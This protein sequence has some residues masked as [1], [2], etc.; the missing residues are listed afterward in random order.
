MRFSLLI[1]ISIFISQSLFSNSLDLYISDV[2][3]THVQDCYGDA[4]GIIVITAEG[5]QTPYSYSVEIGD[6][7]NYQTSNTFTGLIAGTY[8]IKVKDAFNVVVQTY[9]NVY[10]PDPIQIY[11][12]TVTN[13]DGCYGDANGSI[14]ISANGGTGTLTYSINNGSSFQASDNF[15]NLTAGFYTVVVKDGND[16]EVTG[17]DLE[18]TQPDKLELSSVSTM[19]VTGCYNY[20]NGIIDIA[21]TG[22]TEP[23][24][25]SVNNG[26]DFQSGASFTGLDAGSYDIIIKDA[27]DCSISGGNYILTQPDELVIDNIQHTNVGCNGEST[28]DITIT[29]SGGTG[30]LEY[31]ITGGGSYYE[32]SYFGDLYAGNYDIM[33]K[34]NNGC[35]IFGN[36][37]EITEPDELYI[38]NVTKQDVVGCFGDKT[39]KITVTANSGTP[40]YYYSIDGGSTYGALNQNEF[41]NL[42]A[43]T[44][45][46]SVKDVNGCTALAPESVQINQPY[47]FNIYD[48][49]GTDVNTCYGDNTGSLSILA[50]GGTGTYE[51]TI[52]DWATTETSN[53]I[54]NVYAG[55]YT[56]IGQ[57]ANHCKDTFETQIVIKQPTEVVISGAT[58]YNLNCFESNDGRIAINATGGT[59]NLMYSVNG[60]TTFV[61]Y[62]VIT[63][64]SAGTYQ[65]AVRDANSCPA[66]GESLTLTQPDEIIYDDI[67]INNISS[68]FGE[69]N[70]SIDIRV[71]GGTPDYKYSVNSGSDYST[72]SLFSD[73]PAG[74]YNLMV[75]DANGCLKS[76]GAVEITQPSELQITG[77]TKTN[78]HDCKGAATG[79][80]TIDATGGTDPL[81]YSVNGGTDIFENN[82]EFTN[83]T[84][85]TYTM[86]VQDANGCSKLFY[87]I[88]I[89]EPDTLT[90][91]I[92]LNYDVSCYGYDDGKVYLA[93]NGGLPS[94]K[95]SIDGGNTFSYNAQYFNLTAGN[96]DV[97]IEDAYGCRQAG[98]SFTVTEP[99]TLMITMV[100][101]QNI[102]QCY[103]QETGRITLSATGGVLDYY[104]SIDSGTT[105]STNPNFTNLPAGDYNIL[106]ED[107]NECKTIHPVTVTLT[108]PDELVITDLKTQNIDCHGNTNGSITITASGG[109]GT[110]QYSI[111]DEES[112]SNSNVFTNLPAANYNVYVED[113]NGCSK[114]EYQIAIYEP[115]ELQIGYV[116][117]SDES[118]IDFHDGEIRIVAYGGTPPFQFT[119]G[120]GMFT[121][122]TIDNLNPGTYLPKVYDANGCSITAS[123]SVTIGSPQNSA[124][125]SP[126]TTIGCS[127][128]DVQFLRDTDDG[129]TFLW[130]FDDGETSGTNEPLHTFVNMSENP[131][132]YQ[133]T[134]VSYSDAGCRDTAY[135]T[136]TVYPQPHLS[137]S[138]SAD[139]LYYPNTTAAITNTSQY[140]YSDYLWQFGDGTSDT[141]EQ[142]AEHI[143]ESC[144]NY[145]VSLA[146]KNTWC[147]DTV[148]DSIVIMPILPYMRITM[149]TTNGCTP[150]TINFTDL[151]ENY[152]SVSWDMGDGTS[153]SELPDSYTFYNQSAFNIHADV[154]GY[155]NT[156]TTFDTLI[157]VWETPVVNFTVEPDSVLPPD[158]PIHC[159]NLSTGGYSYFWDFGD[160][161]YSE[162][163][164]PVHQYYT[165]GTY[166]IKLIVTSD[167]YCVDSMTLAS[168]VYVLPYGR[169]IFPN[170]FTPNG[171][172]KNDLFLPADYGAI[173]NYEFY[174]YNRWGEQVF[175]SF[176]PDEGW[177]GKF[178]GE[179]VPQD[180]YV[181]MIKGVYKNGTPFSDAGNVT[182][183]R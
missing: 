52:D 4:T 154:K 180:V 41:D 7:E 9:E 15:T 126:Q 141:A 100:D 114:Q 136:I 121:E 155:C 169:V 63:S 171:D 65:V 111:D 28:G 122:S 181:W 68:C 175:E 179:L 83:L 149:D 80:I 57:D 50:T 109:T 166:D 43:S 66:S 144:G 75:K 71:S 16:C 47:K 124:V 165:E 40:G 182:L 13:I 5:G 137:F 130:D 147:S 36:S 59:G 22:G 55:S 143:Y 135:N 177:D 140:T 24:S 18:I 106:V 81:Y 128:L 44:Y 53:I 142:P 99:D 168:E 79:T 76:G 146:A 161:T 108:Q 58:G 31:S 145:T 69:A 85:G 120:T 113:A 56:V 173:K 11:N 148:R 176:D 61:T 74:N 20:K 38:S 93:G 116:G 96:Y 33:V 82:G 118:C 90:A 94:Y 60:G 62:S 105:Y 25:Y 84:A 27:K 17:S 39:G 49:T 164:E 158:Q 30:T 172:G 73:L 6:D 19:D 97:A 54:N 64:L 2:T 8:T 32:T 133:I 183:L 162:E 72:S 89:S 21:V 170:A 1:I 26:A 138:L 119:V 151:S 127:P 178:K 134:A 102:E 107:A 67:I 88:E 123:D 12:E 112:L 103:G 159:Y 129:I 125:F 35:D 91:E 160:S 42:E 45:S 34:D 110:L 139:T 150:L 152:E 132:D 86:Y 92:T 14:E 104:Y 117:S 46:I 131:Q 70:G 51:Y 163:I 78:I 174:I 115:D 3:V 23:I 167:K 95:F 87:T 10:Q 29:A 98:P 156:D 37:V 153:F 157:T 48:V 77:Y 101:Y